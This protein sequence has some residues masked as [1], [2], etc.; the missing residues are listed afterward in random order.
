MVSIAIV[1]DERENIE[2]ISS[3]IRRYYEEQGSGEKEYSIAEFNDGR[4]LLKHYSKNLDILFLDIE[5]RYLDG[6]ST[7]EKIRE[8]N[9]DVVII[10]VTK[11]AQFALKGYGVSALDFVVKPVDYYSFKLR[12]I[13]ALHYLK[14]HQKCRIA[15]SPIGQG[16][17]YLLSSEIRYVEVFGRH[18]VFHTQREEYTVNG[19]LK[20]FE[21]ALRGQGFH[22]CNRY[23]LVN[24]QYVSGFEKNTLLLGDIEIPISRGKRE[25]LLKLLVN[26]T[27]RV[28]EK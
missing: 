25:E 6:M 27:S 9:L 14:K 16:T 18:V 12:F 7:A 4:E 2:Q 19:R 3:Y 8:A 22:Y 28:G 15:V 21:E 10:F 23:C 13:K 17:R 5:M 20:E 11:M 1:D 24:L 26:Y